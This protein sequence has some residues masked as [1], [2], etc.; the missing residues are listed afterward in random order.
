MTSLNEFLYQSAEQS[1]FSTELGEVGGYINLRNSGRRGGIKEFTLSLTSIIQGLTDIK[2]NIDVFENLTNY[3]ESPWRDNGSQYFTDLSLKSLITVQTKPCFTALSKVIAWANEIEYENDNVILISKDSI[4][5]TIDEL[6]KLSQ[7]Y[8]PTESH[9]TKQIPPDKPI[10]QESIIRN[11][12]KSVLAY[13]YSNY[14]P[15]FVNVSVINERNEDKIDLPFLKNVIKSSDNILTADELSTGDAGTQRF[16]SEYLKEQGTYWYISTQWAGEDTE[17]GLCFPNLKKFIES[18]FTGYTAVSEKGIYRLLKSKTIKSHKLPKPFILLAGISGT[19]KS[20][21]VREQAK[22]WPN[23]NN[24]Q[25]VAVR[26]DWHEPSDL[27][28]YVLRLKEKP[29]FISTPVIKFIVYAWLE[30]YKQGIVLEKDENDKL[31]ADC[32]GKQTAPFWLCL[33]EMNLAPVEQYFADYLSVIE[34]REWSEGIYSCDALIPPEFLKDV[35]A[36]NE[37]QVRDAMG[38]LKESIDKNHDA[39]WATIKE[40]G[41]PIPFNLIVA[42]TVNM[43]ETTHDFSRKVIDRAL[44]LD[45]GEFAPNEFDDFF[46][47]ENEKPQFKTLTYPTISQATVKDDNAQKTIAFLQA[48]NQVLKGTLFET[49]YRALNEC[50]LAVECEQPSD[51]KRLQAVWDDFLMM[52]ILPR[53]EGDEDK[54]SSPNTKD[55]NLFI[56]LEK[57]LE[58]Q[59]SEIWE[60]KRPDLLRDNAPD[61][62]CRSKA[63]I[64]RMKNLLENGFTSFWP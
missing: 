36:Q 41:L 9:N 24:F 48:V 38:L 23:T 44:S 7:K 15:T 52:K 45:F 2:N 56:A 12:A 3:D 34:T 21:F 62:E 51:E 46:T 37:P 53:M 64:I 43:D 54:L 30:A 32:S 26:P 5:K 57:V 42:G 60:S 35:I 61:M 19:G 16:F 22:A 13:F 29:E 40:N 55:D 17:R 18:T 11:F 25:L 8:S 59:L 28:G 63:K 27:L 50:L 6:K 49:A 14:H 58:S 1:Q 39:L 33:D 4:N 47:P 31:I 10:I 20:R